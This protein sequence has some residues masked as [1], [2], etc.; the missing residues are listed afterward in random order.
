[1]STSSPKDT[2][3]PPESCPDWRGTAPARHQR[4][5]R[6]GA[7]TLDAAPDTAASS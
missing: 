3:A 4:L 7:D 6:H 2:T 5:Y 1:M